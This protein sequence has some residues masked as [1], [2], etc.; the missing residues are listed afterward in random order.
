MTHHT[1]TV[2]A[3]DTAPSGAPRLPRTAPVLFP[4]VA[5]ACASFVTMEATIRAIL[6]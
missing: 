5:A 4:L 2:P 6:S 3:N 1:N